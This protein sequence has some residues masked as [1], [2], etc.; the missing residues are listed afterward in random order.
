MQGP[1]FFKVY[2]T[3]VAFNLGFLPPSKEL[4]TFH[5]NELDSVIRSLDCLTKKVEE[6]VVIHSFLAKT[7]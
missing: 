6:G 7:S 4:F 2:Q 3:D 1:E 5:V